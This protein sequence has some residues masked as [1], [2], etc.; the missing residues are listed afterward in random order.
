[1]PTYIYETVPKK[2]GA[3]TKRFE[4]KQSM[5]DKPLTKHPETGEPVRRVIAG[6]YG[7]I[8][9]KSA[10]PPRASCCRGG[11]DCNNCECNN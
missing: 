8:A 11:G 7:F 5:K 6:G 3:K 4:I 9:Q 1:M 10:P 2:S